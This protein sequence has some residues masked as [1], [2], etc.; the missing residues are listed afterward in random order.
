[1]AQ[2]KVAIGIDLGTTN[3][4]VAVVRN[5]RVDIIA[6]DIGSR[7]TPSFV[8]FTEDEALVGDAA[9]AQATWNPENTIFDAKRLIGRKYNDPEAQKKM[10][11]W[12]FQVKDHYGNTKIE[13]E[14]KGEKKSYTPEEI[15][16]MVLIK[17]K[18]IA[19]DYVGMDVED[20]VITVP[21]YF[22]DSQRQATMDAGAIAG[23]N[24]L[25]IINEPT[26]AA[27]AYGVDKNVTD[28]R[29]ILVYDLGGGT[30]DVVVLTIENGNFN[31]LAV[32]GNTYLGGGDFDDRLMA[33]FMAEFKRKKKVDISGN[34]RA[35]AKL[36]KACEVAKKNLSS[37]IKERIQI[38]CLY[39]NIN[40]DSSITRVRFEE[41]C[42]DLFAG[43]LSPVAAVLEDAGLVKD[44][45]D[46]IVLAGGSTR[47]PKIQ[48]LL[49]EYFQGK[50]L[51]KTINP[52][53]AVA[54]G[55][56]LHA[57]SLAGENSVEELILTDVKAKSI[58]INVLGGKMSKIIT[59]NTKLPAE[60][61]ERYTTTCHNQTAV[62]IKVYEGDHMMTENN[63]LLGEFTM[64]GIQKAL[65][66]VPQIDVTFSIDRNGILNV[67]AKDSSTSVEQ[68]IT[69]ISN[70]GRLGKDD[71]N[72]MIGEAKS[73]KMDASKSKERTDARA[74]LESS[75]VNM[76]E[77]IEQKLSRGE[78]TQN[79]FTQVEVACDDAY[80]WVDDH[81]RA[82]TEDYLAK[83]TEL[84][85]LCATII[86]GFR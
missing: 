20:A 78:V 22:D 51:N 2:A 86:T 21:A 15:S 53:E 17:M 55:A 46:E 67:T 34:A 80:N 4:C 66:G 64:E 29:N 8:G 57:A 58:G 35:M 43:T 12:P 25:S 32:N 71:I 81:Q 36:R 19:D 1:M 50:T 10:D 28:H 26:A 69:I 24:I 16:S 62:D 14:Y 54:F 13:V 56:A 9:K 5:S 65:K 31:V 60:N 68:S 79:Q 23:L 85:S 42:S 52:D 3:S 37:S 11:M 38:E 44:E 72:R 61:T 18:A 76:K 45:I 82:A 84:E 27:I 74:A 73:F 7:T 39:Q 30:F 6:N 63:K 33:H 47:I 77:Q 59:R 75:C 70:K 41:L 48:Q 40:F 49:K 83:K